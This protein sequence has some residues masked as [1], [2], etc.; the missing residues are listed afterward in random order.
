AAVARNRVALVFWAPLGPPLSALALTFLVGGGIN[1]AIGESPMEVFTLLFRGGLSSFDGFARVLNDATPLMLTGLSVAYAFRAG[2]FNI[3]GEGQLYMGAFAA[4]LVATALPGAPRLLAIPLAI[5]AAATGGAVWGAIPGYL[6]ARFGV[7]EVINTIMMN[8]LAV[9]ITGYLVVHHLKEQGQ[10]IP[11]T[12]E[13]PE[14]YQLDGFGRSAWAQNLGL[15]SANPLGPSLLL[16]LVAVLVVWLIFRRSV[17]GYR[18]RVL[19]LSP[20][21]ARY[22]G[23]STGWLTVRAMAAS[24]ALAGLVGVHEVLLYRHRFLD[25]FSSGLGFLGIAVAL[26]GRNHPLGVMLAAL[27]FGFLNTGALEIDI[28][29]EV[30][31]ELVVVMQAMV[32]LFVVSASELAARRAARRR[33]EKAT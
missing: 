3:G 33:K 4:M 12:P 20:E 9:G 10:M 14:A 11:H 7:H 5:L 29:T 23:I 26:M 18:L 27:L 28:F 31:R 22:S 8:F 32:I 17:E 6:R 2:Y 1:A 16:A 21:A 15:D 13:I 30:P 24:G 19:G 25:N